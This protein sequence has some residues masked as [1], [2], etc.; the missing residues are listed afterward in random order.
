MLVLLQLLQ[1]V[2]HENFN[3]DRGNDTERPCDG[4]AAGTESISCG[5][6]TVSVRGGTLYFFR[7]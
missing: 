5:M 7:S 4:S 2:H 3:I 1:L 6:D